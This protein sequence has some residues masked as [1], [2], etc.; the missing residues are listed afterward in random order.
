MQVLEILR[1]LFLICAIHGIALQGS[2]FAEGIHL[3]R[4]LK[5]QAQAA[6]GSLSVVP[7]WS[8]FQFFPIEIFCG[9][10]VNLLGIVDEQ[11]AATLDKDLTYKVTGSIREWDGE[12]LV[13]HSHV[14]MPGDLELGTFILD[15]MKVEKIET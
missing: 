1:Q 8:L 14:V 9:V 10:H 2:V 3:A 15:D 13:V 11:T 5:H 7:V 12:N 6:I 4:L